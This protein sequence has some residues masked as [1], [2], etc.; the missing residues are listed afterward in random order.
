MTDL[1]FRSRL[2]VSNLMAAAYGMEVTSLEDPVRSSDPRLS[3]E[4]S[5][6]L[7]SSSLLQRLIQSFG[8]SSMARCQEDILLTFSQLVA[9][10]RTIQQ[11]THLPPACFITRTLFDSEIY[12]C[13]VSWST[14]EASGSEAAR[15]L[16]RSQIVSLPE[17]SGCHGAVHS[18]T[19]CLSGPGSYESN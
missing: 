15:A 5:K 3:L 17:C 16:Q 18:S 19:G 4:R 10:L 6:A 12:S 11:S 13:M 9:Y 7:E 2:A 8:R 1:Q 14:L